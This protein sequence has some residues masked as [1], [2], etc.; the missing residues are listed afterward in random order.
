MNKPAYDQARDSFYATREKYRQSRAAYYET[1]WFRYLRRWRL[2]GDMLQYSLEMERHAD[3]L[4]RSV[5]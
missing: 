1:P 4:E 3:A 5:A 2:S